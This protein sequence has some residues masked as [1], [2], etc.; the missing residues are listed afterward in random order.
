MKK[1]A[2][3]A[4]DA[5]DEHLRQLSDAFPEWTFYRQ[6]MRKD[7]DPQLVAQAEIIACQRDTK[8]IHAAKNARWIHTF[9]A[10]V[11]GLFDALQAAHPEGGVPLTNSAG[12]YGTPIA[13][14]SLALLMALSRRLDICISQMPKGQWAFPGMAREVYESTVGILGTGDIG[15]HL[16][17]MVKGLGARVLG[18]RRRESP[19]APPFDAFYHGDMLD[20]MLPL[21]DYVCVC[22]PGTPH[23]RGLLDARRIQLM[24]PGAIVTNIGRGFIIDTDAL[25]QA[26]RSGAIA[27]AGL[28]VTAPEPLPPDHPLW[29]M[30]NV[31]ITPHCS[32]SSPRDTARKVELFARNMRAFLSGQPLP[33]L[34]DPK[35]EY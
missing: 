34:V 6:P 11:D 21:C 32:H 1:I 5:T 25:T 26:L 24:K 31:I 13:E 12:A 22:L 8:M 17:Y 15:T 35:W 18:Y 14:H 19:A 16:A 23:T 27:G 9:S 7:F 20:E 29:R 2:V 10:G 4:L 30:P 28:D 33:N 3:I